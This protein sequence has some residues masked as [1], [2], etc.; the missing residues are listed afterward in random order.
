MYKKN[1]C[2]T[3][4]FMVLFSLL[5]LPSVAEGYV[6][7][8]DVAFSDMSIEVEGVKLISH[9]EP[10]IYED[11]IWVP[12]KDLGKGLGLKVSFDRNKK[13]IYLDSDGKL[14]LNIN[15]SKAPISFQM[16]YE[17][18]AKERII[19]DLEDEID[20]IESGRSFRK[21]YDYKDR[22][23]IKNIKVYFGNVK[24]YLDKN[25]LDIDGILY[26]DDIYVPINDISPHLYIT[27]TYKADR[28]VLYI[29]GNGVLVK[30]KRYS[31]IDNLLAFRE[32][33]N[34]L[35]GIQ[36]EQLMMRKNVVEKLNI[37]Y[38]KLNT[39]KDLESYLN[40]H[41]SKIGE[42]ST[43]IE[44]RDYP[45]K[46]LYLDIGFTRNNAYKWTKLKRSDV[47]NWVWD[48]Y[49]AITTLYNEEALIEGAIRNPY[50]YRYSSSSHKNYVKFNTRDNDLYFDF[51]R[52]LLKKDY[53]IEPDYLAEN[54]EKTLK[55]YNKVEFSYSAETNGDD[56]S[57]TVFCNSNS[58][59]T[60]SLYTKMGY[61]KKLN[62]EIKRVYPELEISGKIV[63]PN[64]KYDPVRFNIAENR[65]RSIDLLRETEEFLNTNF[66]SFSYGKHNFELK[67]GIYEDGL[68]SFR[69]IVESDFSVDDDKWT[70]A[71]STGEQKLSNKV[72]NAISFIISLWDGNVS[73]EVVDKNNITIKEFDIYRNNVGIVYANP[74]SG[75]IKEGTKVHL[76]TDTPGASIYYTLDGSIPTTNSTLYTGPITVSRDLEINAFGYKEGL[77]EGP[78]STHSYTVVLDDNWSYGL[79]DL[80]VDSGVLEPSFARDILE[81][82]VYVAGNVDSITLTPFAKS[83]TITVDGNTVESGKSKVVSLSELKNTISISVKESNKIERI[84]TVIVYK[85]NSGDTGIDLKIDNF[86]TNVVGV[87]KGQLYSTGNVVSDFSGYK[88]ELLSKTEMSYGKVAIDS[89]GN[90]EIRDF[91]IDPI[92]KIIGY[93]YKVY[94][95]GGKLVLEGNLK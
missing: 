25:I 26:N 20:I 13:S 78:M 28:N 39:V 75:E 79:T 80:K 71:G 17:I 49:T 92:S 12:L 15:E 27:P 64:E 57:L 59:A 31:S 48:M 37:P 45:G 77:G 56:M 55:K 4:V 19:D 36:M 95:G 23:K 42:L 14:K 52:S 11:D 63:F 91:A 76:Y 60:W 72:H 38:G 86:N 67:Y 87:F 81:Y 69:M 1:I 90:F 50:Y 47:E 3:L 24:V 65:I 46:W 74:S 29:D 54:L 58:F 35:L 5:P 21:I 93:K 9:K 73:T 62:W 16:G 84:Y 7:D 82:E 43:T 89:D 66:N 41:F 22:S 83:G 44:V 51:T 68:D 8:I 61:L 30:N 85:G 94:D 34:Y 33:R 6:K 18:D 40:K 32:G 2:I 53:R 70:S 10:F 88:I